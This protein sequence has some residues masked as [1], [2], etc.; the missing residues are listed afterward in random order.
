MN[1]LIADSVILG[2]M[3]EEYELTRDDIPTHFPHIIDSKLLLKFYDSFVLNEEDNLPTKEFLNSLSE[4]NLITLIKDM[5]YL[6]CK[7][8]Q[9]LLILLKSRNPN[10]KFK[11]NLQVEFDKIKCNDF[12]CLSER[13]IVSM[14]FRNDSLNLF[15]IYNID[16]LVEVVIS[17]IVGNSLFYAIICGALNIFRHLFPKTVF[18]TDDE[19]EKLRNN[20]AMDML[21]RSIKNEKQYVFLYNNNIVYYKEMVEQCISNQMHENSQYIL[22]ILLEKLP[23]IDNDLIDLIMVLKLFIDKSSICE[24]LCERKNDPN[25]TYENLMLKAI[26]NN[27]VE[28]MDHLHDINSNFNYNSLKNKL[29]TNPRFKSI[30]QRTINRL[31]E[32]GFEIKAIAY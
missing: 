5:K 22:K 32:R 8:T 6:G 26:E 18:L 12:V 21:G 4:D 17:D 23:T 16:F 29:S 31:A 24:M 2:F 28:F 3:F 9:D 11:G 13:K 1:N 25:C 15:K 20:S 14:V 7:F 30:Y 27:Y 10:V 19:M